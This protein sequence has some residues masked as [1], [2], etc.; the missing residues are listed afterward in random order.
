MLEQLELAL[1][2]ATGMGVILEHKKNKLQA[3]SVQAEGWLTLWLVTLH[4]RVI[5]LGLLGRIL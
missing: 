1:C 4:Q 3:E 5:L 2:P